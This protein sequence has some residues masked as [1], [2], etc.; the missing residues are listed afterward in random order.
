MLRRASAWG[1]AWPCLPHRR[2]SPPPP[3]PTGLPTATA[4][5]TGTPVPGQPPIVTIRQPT[6]GTRQAVRQDAT[7]PYAVVS[8][9]GLADDFDSAP[10]L[11]AFEWSSDTEGQLGSAPTVTGVRLHIFGFMAQCD[12]P[13]GLIGDAST[14]HVVTLRVTDETGAVGEQS[15]Q[16]TVEA[17]CRNELPSDEP[18]PTPSP[19]PTGT[20]EPTFAVSCD[21]ASH[22]VAA[23]VREQERRTSQCT[24]TPD[25]GFSGDVAWS[26]SVNG[27]PEFTCSVTPPFG[28]LDSGATTTLTITATG[29]QAGSS[30]TIVVSASVDGIVKTFTVSVLSG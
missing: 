17:S 14:T 16:V 23:D 9:D 19:Q 15:V 10:E 2:T 3:A 29:E 22:T 11:L 26:C 21:P 24:A 4:S 18:S 30:A 13:L 6:S 27:P 28:D 25:E 1:E 5:P 20:Q 12:G 7:G 8:L